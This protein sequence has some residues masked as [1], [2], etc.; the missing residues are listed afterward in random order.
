MPLN[1]D[2]FALHMSYFKVDGT[3]RLSQRQKKEKQNREDCFFREA[4]NTKTA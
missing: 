4:V 3:G 2:I 1:T